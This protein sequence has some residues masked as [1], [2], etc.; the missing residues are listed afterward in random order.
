MRPSDDPKA[1]VWLVSRLMAS[2]RRDSMIGDLVEQRRGGRSAW[3]FWRQAVAAIVVSWAVRVWE[4]RR[5]ALGITLVSA[6]LNEAW[7][8]SGIWTWV[9]RLHT[10][11]YQ[12]LLRSRWNWLATDPWAYRLRPYDWTTVLVWCTLLAVIARALS[13]FRPR[14]RWLV[15]VPMAIPQVVERLPHLQGAYRAWRAAPSDP[16]WLYALLWYAA[17]TLV[18]VPASILAGSGA[19]RT[20]RALQDSQPCGSCPRRI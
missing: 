4:H 13:R 16:V 11:W 3:W 18:V 5:L 9:D 10:A 2:D 12:P 20:R 8:R 19:W 1:A 15:A 17:L 14:E 7:M 6:V